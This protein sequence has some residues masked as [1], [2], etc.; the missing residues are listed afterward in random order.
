MLGLGPAPSFN[1]EIM[2]MMARGPGLFAGLSH[3]GRRITI[4]GNTLDSKAQIVSALAGANV[5]SNDP[6][7]A[8]QQLADAVAPFRGGPTPIYASED[9]SIPGPGGNIPVRLYWPGAGRLPRPILVWF[10][11][12]GF[13]LGS[14][15]SHDEPCRRLARACDAVVISVEYRL[16]PEAKFPAGLDDCRAA[17]AW[18]AANAADIGGDPA[19]L[20]VGGDSAG[21]NLAA[22]L[23]LAC[24]DQGG[25]QP[26]FQ[27]LAYPVTDADMAQRSYKLFADGFFLTAERM[28]W[29]FDKYLGS[30]DQGSDP[31]VS[32]LKAP[33]LSDLAP[34]HVITAG[35][36][37]LR[38]EGR[39]YAR[40]LE[41]A[42]VAVEHV[43][44]PTMTHAFFSMA[45]V[46]AQAS[47]AT[48]RA[49]RAMRAAFA[50]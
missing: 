25:P 13:V 12:G 5:A 49:A 46:F 50:A 16:A 41:E 30:P 34:A 37:P 44:Y 17:F 20:A 47:V 4:D 42:G 27:L 3:L 31:L 2:V 18:A 43:E 21:G 8:R 36:D 6:V 15:E 23:T 7:E 26:G 22:A 35:F 14:V 10:H 29:F 32:P 39:A 19:R 28:G 11:G 48:E 1:P 9:R 40:R 33:D 38:D 24:R 45:G